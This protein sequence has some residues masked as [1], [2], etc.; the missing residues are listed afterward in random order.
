MQIQ[1]RKSLAGMVAAILATACLGLASSVSHKSSVRGANVT[2]PAMTK[3]NTGAKLPAGTYWM[4]VTKN[5]PT[6]EVA[7][8][9]EE[10]QSWESSGGDNEAV[11]TKPLATVK[12]RVVA[13]PAKNKHTEV[14]SVQRGDAQLVRT[15]RP[16]G[17]AEEL[18]FAANGM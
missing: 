3:F 9:K 14:D 6:P 10:V 17:W 13:Q 11:G 18:V 5:S 8:Y 4:E 16:R 1:S 12:A 15:I 2:F 7:F